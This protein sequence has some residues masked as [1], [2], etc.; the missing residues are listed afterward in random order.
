[1]PAPEDYGRLG[2]EKIDTVAGENETGNAARHAD[3]NGYGAHPRRQ[4]CGE[5]AAVAGADDCALRDRLAGRDGIADHGAVERRLI[6]RAANIIGRLNK[7]VR[8][9]LI[10]EGVRRDDGAGRERSGGDQNFRA[11]DLRRGCG[12]SQRSSAAAEEAPGKHG[13]DERERQRSGHQHQLS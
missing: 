9:R 3:R 5:E 13:G 6:G 7:V 12:L 2:E 8:P 4:R 1:L 10:P 11:G